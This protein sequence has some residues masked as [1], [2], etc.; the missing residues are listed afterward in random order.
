MARKSEIQMNTRTVRVIQLWGRVV[1]ML[2][3]CK[4]S[5]S[6]KPVMVSVMIICLAYACSQQQIE[7]IQIGV[8]LPL[9]EQMSP[10]GDSVRKGLELALLKWNAQLRESYKQCEL[11]YADTKGDPGYAKVKLVRLINNYHMPIIIG[12]VTS[13]EVITVSST[14]NEQKTVIISPTA[15][16][17]SVSESGEYVFRTVASDV[18]EG[19]TM[20]QVCYES[21]HKKMAQLILNNEFGKGLQQSFQQRFLQLGGAIA[22]TIYFE[23]HTTVFTSYFEQL[24]AENPDGVYVVGYYEELIAFFQQATALRDKVHIF[25][26]GAFSFDTVLKEVGDAAEGIICTQ[27][28]DE[29][30][31]DNPDVKAF[32]YA[33]KEH[34]GSEPDTFSAY[35][36]DTMNFIMHVIERS[37]ESGLPLIQGLFEY[38]NFKGVTGEIAFDKNGDVVKTPKIYQIQNGKLEPYKKT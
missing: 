31:D 16:A 38:K 22:P 37:K 27:P 4:L 7:Y 12:P 17:P 5:Q 36:Y 11:I 35:A 24:L 19:I 29:M 9:T 18:A 26:S 20:A 33:Y 23:P 2:L 32:R 6:Y 34:Y 25:V 14:A 30:S 15:T 3:F 8:L 21:G 28:Y 1:T 10:I 13:D